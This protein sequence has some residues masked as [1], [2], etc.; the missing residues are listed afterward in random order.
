M[1]Y[2]EYLQTPTWK[3]L[4]QKAIARAGSRCQLCNSPKKLE[5]HHR[6][7][8]NELGAEELLDLTVLCKSCHFV[9]TTVIQGKGVPSKHKAKIHRLPQQATSAPVNKSRN[10]T[11]KDRELKYQR[12]MRNVRQFEKA[13]E[14]A[15]REGKTGDYH[16]RLVKRW[17]KRALQYE[18]PAWMTTRPTAEEMPKVG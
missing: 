11:A 6:C 15:I 3:D 16:R 12:C 2:S 5:V 14:R 18:D 7:Y 4:R 8:P 17:K 13:V 1:N 10:W 9:V